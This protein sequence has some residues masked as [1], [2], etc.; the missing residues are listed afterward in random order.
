MDL[1]NIV[2]MKYGPYYGED[3]LAVI[4]RKRLE[5]SKHDFF[6]WGYGGKTCHPINRLRP[7]AE[8]AARE[9]EKVYLALTPTKSKFGILTTPK[10]RF[11]EARIKKPGEGEFLPEGIYVYQ[12][13]YALKCGEL[14]EVNRI[15][16]LNQYVIALDKIQPPRRLQ[17]YL[18]FQID[19]ACAIY[20]PSTSLP[21]N[22]NLVQIDY[23]AE[24]LPPYSYFLGD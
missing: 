7:F 3:A 12:S 11:S 15:I 18:R 13:A 2:L 6:F 21:K 10:M 19:K 1:Q 4:N 14:F 24:L 23:V 5:F 17:D 22:G 16:D 9:G 20:S 8:R